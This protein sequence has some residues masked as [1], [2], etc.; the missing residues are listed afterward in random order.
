MTSRSRAA[1]ILVI[2][3]NTD[4]AFG[5]RNNLEIDGHLVEVA[6]DGQRGLERARESSPDLVILDLMLP[7]LDG[8]RV[9]RAARG[10]GLTMPILVLT[11][12]GEEADKVRGLKLGADDYVTKPF[13]LLELLARVEALLRRGA[14]TLPDSATLERFGDIEV[15]S[16]AR[17]VTRDGASI[18]LAPK[19]LDLL[20][21]LIRHRGAVVSRL[22]LM[23][24]VWGYTAAV[25]SRTVDTHVAALRK[26]L[27][28]D[29]SSPRHILTTRK[30][31]YRWQP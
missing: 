13:G 30:A 14:P 21:A 26:K 24:E 11:A 18:E 4:L 29:P 19:E 17:T 16:S 22:D 3:D 2:E 23:R 7:K 20:L 1:R 15:N 6:E 31:G 12:R 8:F 25:V 9:L 27:E 28:D 10:E 5:L